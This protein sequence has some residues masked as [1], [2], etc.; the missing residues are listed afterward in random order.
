MLVRDPNSGE[1]GVRHDRVTLDTDGSSA[2][3][4]RSGPIVPLVD[5][6]ETEQPQNVKHRLRCLLTNSEGTKR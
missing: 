6:L 1:R 4:V 5:F 3:F 2:P